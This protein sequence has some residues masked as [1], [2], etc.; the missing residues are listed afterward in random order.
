MFAFVVVESLLGQNYNAFIDDILT[1][2]IV[3]LADMIVSVR[4]KNH[5]GLARN[6][7]LN[8]IIVKINFHYIKM[9]ASHN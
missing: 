3:F 9:A 2:S 7:N 4:G 8:C 1:N 6:W 5:I